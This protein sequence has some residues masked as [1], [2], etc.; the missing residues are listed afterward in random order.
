MFIYWNKSLIVVKPVSFGVGTQLTVHKPLS[1]SMNNPKPLQSLASVTTVH[2][3]RNL[4]FPNL[5]HVAGRLNYRLTVC[6]TMNRG[7]AVGTAT[8]YGLDC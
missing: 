7:S 3:F 8:G 4:M 2:L 5:F 1:V 6:H